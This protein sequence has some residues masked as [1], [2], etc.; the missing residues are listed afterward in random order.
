MSKKFSQH[1]EL[2]LI[3]LFHMFAFCFLRMILSGRLTSDLLELLIL[4]PHLSAT[5]VVIFYAFQ[6]LSSIP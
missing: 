3:R 4:L 5:T 6:R 1:I 2:K